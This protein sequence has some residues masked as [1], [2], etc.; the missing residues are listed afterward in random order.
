MSE[1]TGGIGRLQESLELLGI[2]DPGRFPQPV[3]RVI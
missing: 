2:S 1:H 3:G